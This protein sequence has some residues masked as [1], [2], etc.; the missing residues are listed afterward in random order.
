M[1]ISYVYLVVYSE[2][3]ATEPAV[4]IEAEP[5]LAGQSFVRHGG[6]K[7]L[8]PQQIVTNQLD[9]STFATYIT[10]RNRDRVWF[11]ALWHSARGKAF[12]T[13][14]QRKQSARR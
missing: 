8:F 14:A 3:S 12:F 1:T 10:W 13:A 4:E 6:E 9:G 7:I 11:T 5:E 2:I